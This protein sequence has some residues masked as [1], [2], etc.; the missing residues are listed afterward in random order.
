MPRLHK[1][2]AAMADE[3]DL[4]A[5]DWASLEPGHGKGLTYSSS[6]KENLEPGTYVELRDGT[7]GRIIKPTTMDG[8]KSEVNVFRRLGAAFHIPGFLPDTPTES[9]I[10]Y[11][12]EV[13]QTT[14]VKH[15]E[16]S[17]IK[18]IIF[19]F[20][21]KDMI[22]GKGFYCDSQ[23][24]DN[25]F[26][27]RYRYE[28]D[29]G[30]S[31][32]PDN[33]C[34]PFPSSYEVFMEQYNTCVAFDL[35]KGLMGVKRDIS[36]VMGRSSMVQ[37]NFFSEKGSV[38]NV[39]QSTWSH[40]LRRADGVVLLNKTKR[41]RI[42]RETSNGMD[43]SRKSVAR[44][45]ESIR[46]ETNLHL[47]MLRGLF[48]ET[49]VSSQRKRTKTARLELNDAINHVHGTE[50][51]ETPF[52]QRTIGHQGVDLEYDPEIGELQVKIRYGKYTYKVDDDGR[53]DCPD[54]QLKHLI[55]R[56]NP[57]DVKIVDGKV[58]LNTSEATAVEDNTEINAKDEFEIDGVVYTVARVKDG[59]VWTTTGESFDEQ[60][61]EV[62]RRINERLE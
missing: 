59:R 38:I 57:Y 62:L 42:F 7:I 24:M 44:R 60:S 34:L 36:R 50:M 28:V 41:K 14:E 40:I 21:F 10:R 32:I 5:R 9:N 58:E 25:A 19:V 45:C 52:C 37:A 61:D 2:S 4:M 47:H 18:N 20:K 46:F 15:V 39:N 23:G 49:V 53:A 16:S 35:W 48:G 13:V 11:V 33:F 51:A 29:V 17:A 55:D 1:N 26:L 30:H 22:S 12:P 6:M 3:G 43:M 31:E 8:N 54:K 27:L 56:G